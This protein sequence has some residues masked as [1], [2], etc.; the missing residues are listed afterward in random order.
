MTLDQAKQAC[1]T[2]Y[3]LSSS[4]VSQAA[5]EG[6]RNVANNKD[7]VLP[8]DALGLAMASCANTYIRSESESASEAIRLAKNE[9][10]GERCCVFMC[11]VPDPSF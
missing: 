9:D 6:S 4:L 11:H 7:K 5:E 1:G 10:Y 2:R 3:S 8:I